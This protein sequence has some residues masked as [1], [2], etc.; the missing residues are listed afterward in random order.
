MISSNLCFEAWAGVWTE[1]EI[2]ALIATSFPQGANFCVVCGYKA[3]YY[4]I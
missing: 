3:A 1:W 2:T 4:I